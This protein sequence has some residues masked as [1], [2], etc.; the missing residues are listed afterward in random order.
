MQFSQDGNMGTADAE[1]TAGKAAA[2]VAVGMGEGAE[3]MQLQIRAVRQRTIWR[4]MLSQWWTAT[5][6][7]Q[8]Q[9]ELQLLAW[10]RRRR[11]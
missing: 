4:E 10:R 8:A 5:G 3:M 9:P 7:P 1:A 6:L 11:W 2:V